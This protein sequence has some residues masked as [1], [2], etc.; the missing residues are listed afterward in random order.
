[1]KDPDSSSDVKST[2]NAEDMSL[3]DLLGGGDDSSGDKPTRVDHREDEPDSG[4]VNLAKMV[5]G[6]S[7]E[8]AKTPSIMPPPADPTG[9][10]PIGDP[11]G[12][13]QTQAGVVAAQGQKKGSGP[14]IA[15]IVV[16]LL[17]AAAIIGYMA[18][19]EEPKQ[20]DAAAIA[21]AKAAEAFKAELEAERLANR[22]AMEDMMAKMAALSEKKTD[23]ENEGASEED[24]AK[25]EELQKQMEEAKAKEEEL[26]KKAEEAQKEEAAPK[27]ASSAPKKTSSGDSTPAKKA[28]PTPK[29]KADP[30]PKA[31]TSTKKTGTDELDSLLGGGKK[32]EAKAPEKKADDGIP[33]TPSKPDITKAMGP[34]QA[35][36]QQSCAKY[37]TGTVQV[38]M[39]VG[40]NGRVKSASPKGAFAGNQAGQ[41][42]AMMARSAKFPKFKD[43]SFSFLYPIILK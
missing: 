39:V 18:T 6:S 1:M 8:A 12:V 7:V 22:K 16:V 17:A 40:S 10:Q 14:I 30:A 36:A 34:V 28:D 2:E 26:A 42:V 4:M 43:P 11:S 31:D 24:A 19:R 41:C 13:V 27:K 5:A 38:Q 35:R 32:E 21:A 15:L 9:S 25:L 3:A 33:N 29:K 37:S 23:G 20:D